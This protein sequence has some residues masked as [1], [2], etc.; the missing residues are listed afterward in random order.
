MTDLIPADDWSLAI[1]GDQPTRC[2]QTHCPNFAIVS[3]VKADKRGRGRK[4]A[5]CERCADM[6]RLF[7]RE[8]RVMKLPAVFSDKVLS[9]T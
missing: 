1:P 2:S 9:V 4:W 8:G 5:Y 6:R 3:K 7:V